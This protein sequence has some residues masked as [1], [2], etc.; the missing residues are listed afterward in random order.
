MFRKYNTRYVKI[1][2]KKEEVKEEITNQIKEQ[3][4]PIAIKKMRNK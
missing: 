2:T 4:K 1:T 3:V